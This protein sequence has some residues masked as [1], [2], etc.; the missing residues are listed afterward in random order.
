MSHM[1]YDLKIK[2]NSGLIVTLLFCSIFLSL[3]P[4]SISAERVDYN[5]SVTFELGERITLGHAG[6][7]VC[8]SP[9]NDAG[10]GGDV[11]NSALT[12]YYLGID[13]NLST[14]G[15]IDDISDWADF[16]EIEVSAGK[17]VSVEL[18]VPAGS[19]FDLYIKDSTNSTFIDASE[20]NDPLESVNFMTNISETYFIWVNWWGGSGVYGLDVWTNNSTPKPDLTVDSVVCPSVANLGD[21][22]QIDF[23]VNNIGS[24]L[25][26]NP[27]DISIILSSDT[28][29]DTSDL[30]LN[31]QIQGPNLNSMSTQQMSENVTIPTTLANNSTYYWIIWADAWGNLTEENELNN[32]DYS[33]FPTT[34]GN[35]PSQNDASTGADLADNATNATNFI[36]SNSIVLTG[37]IGGSDTDDWLR[38]SHSSNEGVAASLSFDTG[39]DFDFF[40]YD[41]T[42][43]NMINSSAGLSNPENVSTNGTSLSSSGLVY[44]QILA[45]S[46]SGNWTLT[47]WKFSV[48]SS[49]NPTLSLTMPDKDN[50]EALVTGLT[51]G[52]SYSLEVTLYD[53][54][55]NIPVAPGFSWNN[56][57]S[58][59]STLSTLN[60]VA[61]ST[62]YFYNYSFSTTDAEGEYFVIGYLYENNIFSSLDYD[63]IYYDVLDGSILNDTAG[64]ILINNV[65]LN[66]GTFEIM[67]QIVD[68]V[69]NITHEVGNMY[70]NPFINPSLIINWN[71]TLNLNEHLFEAIILDSN[72]MVTGSFSK[73]FQPVN[74]PDADGDGWPDSIDDCPTIW[75]NSTVDKIGCTDTDGDGWSDNNDVFPFDPTEWSD[76][77]LDGYGDNSD[78]FPF[79]PT[80]WYDSDFDGYGDNSDNCPDTWGDSY[81]DQEGC[82]DSDGDGWSDA[83]DAFPM[84]PNEWLD[85]DGDGYGD[86]S[87]AFPL[88]PTEWVDTDGDGYGDNSDDCSNLG[89]DSWVDLV[90]CPDTD[91][92]GYSDAG[93]AFPM[94]PT[95][96]IDSD[97]DG[98]GDNSDDCLNLAGTSYIDLIGCSDGDGDGYSGF[99]DEFPFDPTEWIDSDGDGIGDNSDDCSQTPLEEIADSNGCSP[100]Q[101]DT[102]A[103]GVWDSDDD[104]MYTNSSNWDSDKDGCI[105]DTDGDGLLDPED[106]CKNEDSSQWD[107][108]QDGCIDDTDGDLIKDNK[109]ACIIQDSTGYDSDGDGCIDDSDNDNV[110]DGFDDCRFINSTGFDSDGDGCIDDSDGDKIKDN[111]DQCRMESS[112]GFDTDG[113][114]CIDDSDGDQIKDNDDNCSNTPTGEGVDDNGCS[115]SQLDDDSDKVMNHLDQCDDTPTG[116]DV[117]ENGCSLISQ[118]ANVESSEEELPLGLISLIGISFIGLIIG[119]VIY[120]TKNKESEDEIKIYEEEAESM[121]TNSI[122]QTQQTAKIGEWVDENGV[123][124][125]R[126]SNGVLYQWNKETN[127]WIE[128]Y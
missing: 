40:M 86:N 122:Q 84:N 95:E 5:A 112:I 109:D 127:E 38:V 100:S 89:G 111:E 103:D 90:G 71:R 41:N 60:W 116:A 50:A 19:D 25:T 123:Y 44:L 47:I 1:N 78:E 7:A 20:Y 30:I 37:E 113:D 87:D 120:L 74:L 128:V 101:K 96:W 108:D 49:S 57:P 21:T 124:W 45:Y 67:W 76:S 48:S 92:D 59:N 8:S 15:C 16:Y 83:G 72:G 4:T 93:D 58:S 77:D 32:L 36:F 2:R 63:V 91:Y 107:N 35:P 54:P 52:N 3:V 110:P 69:S 22:V 34:I 61:T 14:N 104:C 42:S 121:L 28:V 119:G 94:D 81:M 43:T 29:Y 82:L 68:N 66:N 65:H 18:T 64:E 51:V 126:S 11:G 46:G 23:N 24:V 102:D 10:T 97:M 39:N 114:G 12:S 33:F 31:I 85:S 118:S 27:Y 13:V 80:E 105:D 70:I 62:T 79:D 75:G 125:N 56:Y 115:E 99:G 55:V 9:Q 26:M 98:Y 17:D 88:N 73:S 117:D 53:Y 6:K 106:N